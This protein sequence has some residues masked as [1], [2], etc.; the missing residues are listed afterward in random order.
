MV[1]KG[2][3]TN[4]KK[5]VSYDKLSKK[6]KKQVDAKARTMFNDFGC[7]SPVTKIVPDKKKEKQRRRCREKTE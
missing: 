1:K 7:L 3:T 6:A 4:M 2:W 5:C